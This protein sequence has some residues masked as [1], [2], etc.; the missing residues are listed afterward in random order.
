[1]GANVRVVASNL[2]DA[3]TSDVVEET[4]KREL[5]LH[6]YGYPTSSDQISFRHLVY[7]SHLFTSQNQTAYQS[8]NAPGGAY[9]I[10]T[11][12]NRFHN[13]S[14]QGISSDLIILNSE[15]VYGEAPTKPPITGAPWAND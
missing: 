6:L 5:V 8:T 1:M 15:L 7:T 12:T 2:Y 10:V 14:V 3:Y 4:G 11:A 13:L 9:N